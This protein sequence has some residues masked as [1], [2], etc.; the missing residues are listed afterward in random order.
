MPLILEVIVAT[1]AIGVFTK[2]F[3]KKEQKKTFGNYCIC[4]TKGKRQVSSTYIPWITREYENE[5]EYI[6]DEKM[7]SNIALNSEKNWF[8]RMQGVSGF[9][10]VDLS[11]GEE[12]YWCALLK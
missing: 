5:E 7:L 1:A 10:I 9:A 12:H 4:K 3:F 11:T 8:F 6:E 2:F